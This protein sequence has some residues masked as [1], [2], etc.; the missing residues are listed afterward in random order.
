MKQMFCFEKMLKNNH[1]KNYI[2]LLYA[3]IFSILYWCFI[4]ICFSLK[5][6]KGLD[7]LA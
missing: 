4:K 2:Q 3:F 5:L 6:V 1:T 7:F